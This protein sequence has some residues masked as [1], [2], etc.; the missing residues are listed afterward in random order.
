MHAKGRGYKKRTCTGGHAS[1]TRQYLILGLAS[2]RVGS[3]KGSTGGVPFICEPPHLL[4]HTQTE[5]V[6]K[7]GPFK[8]GLDAQTWVGRYITRQRGSQPT[9]FQ[10]GGCDSPRCSRI[11]HQGVCQSLLGLC[12]EGAAFTISSPTPSAVS[13]ATP[14]KQSHLHFPHRRLHNFLVHLVVLHL[15]LGGSQ[16][17]LHVPHNGGHLNFGLQRHL[18]QPHAR[19]PKSELS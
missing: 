13:L 9:A 8:H 7:F 14:A 4:L 5:M 3:A 18:V 19:G 12:S 10:P 16:L 1:D 17:L 6:H 15:L 11:A 2:G